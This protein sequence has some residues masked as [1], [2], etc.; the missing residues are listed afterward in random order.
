MTH[1]K[2]IHGTPDLI[3]DKSPIKTE[4]QPIRNDTQ[5]VNIH[6]GKR[7]LP[8]SRIYSWGSEGCQEILQ[9]EGDETGSLLQYW[10]HVF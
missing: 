6:K 9:G 7:V 8:R 10:E 4:I 1:S 5:A 2:R 3:Y